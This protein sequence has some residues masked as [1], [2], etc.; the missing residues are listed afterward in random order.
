MKKLR[1]A[2]LG[3][4]TIGRFVLDHLAD[5]VVPGCEP[6]AVYLRSPESRKKKHLKSKKIP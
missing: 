4:G 2:I 3:C 1:V 6:V 5:G